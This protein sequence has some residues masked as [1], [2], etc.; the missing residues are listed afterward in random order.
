M[1][2]LEEQTS[3]LVLEHTT[4]KR[5]HLGP[6]GSKEGGEALLPS[7][8]VLW[9]MVVTNGGIETLGCSPPPKFGT[10]LLCMLMSQLMLL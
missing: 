3:G 1:V 7:S 2:C 4:L 6:P 8:I 10:E 5:Y 9:T